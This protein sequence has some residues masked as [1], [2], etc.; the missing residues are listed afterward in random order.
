MKNLSSES[1]FEHKAFT[2]RNNKFFF[3]AL[4]IQ[5]QQS[6]LVAILKNLPVNTDR[7]H[8]SL[9]P[10]SPIDQK[11]CGSHS[12]FCKWLPNEIPLRAVILKVWSEDSGFLNWKKAPRILKTYDLLIGITFRLIHL[13]TPCFNVI[14]WRF[15]N[16]SG[17][18]ACHL[19]CIICIQTTILIFL[20]IQHKCK[21]R[22]N[23][24]VILSKWPRYIT[25]V[26]VKCNK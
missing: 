1:H 19:L 26:W 15:M 4:T 16:K 11:I 21:T 5:R 25:V 9:F 13:V 18:L 12:A 3:D 22:P 2:T 8:G 10:H 14:V 20:L 6:T 17:K 7:L 24:A 23:S